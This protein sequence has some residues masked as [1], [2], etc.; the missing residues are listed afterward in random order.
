[1]RIETDGRPAAAPELFSTYGHFTAMQVR[2]AGVQGLTNHLDRLDAAHRELFGRPLPGDRVR[3][4]V[5]HALAGTADASVRVMLRDAERIVVSVDDPHY[6]PATP[7]RLRSVPYLRPFAHLKHLGGFAQLEWARRVRLDGYDDALLTAPDG[8]V[9][10]SSTANLGFFAPDGAVVWPDAPHLH[11]TAM[12]LVEATTPSIRRPVRADDVTG[13]AGAFLVSS[14]GVVAV[15]SIDHVR[16]PDAGPL[17]A[18]LV[19]RLAAVPWER[20]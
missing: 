12:Q 4:L 14:L 2:S 5:R 1:M 7:Q 17:L 20:V 13:F 8:A 18:G 10:E 15:A 16:L 19:E 11:G 3:D 6:P 9:A